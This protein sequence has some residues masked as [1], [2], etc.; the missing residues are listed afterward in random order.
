MKEP[1][2]FKIKKIIIFPLCV[3]FLSHCS[4]II[5]DSDK[6]IF[7]QNQKAEWIHDKKTL[8]SADSLF[9]LEDPTPLFRKVFFLKDSP[10]KVTLHITAAGYYKA[11]INTSHLEKNIL[12]PAWTDFSKRIY[13]NEYNI[14]PKVTKGMNCLAV[15]LGNGFY[16]PLPLKMW[17]KINLRERLPVGKPRFIAK[18]TIVHQ[19]GKIEEIV[20]DTSWK[21]S[22]GPTIKNSIYL[23]THYDARKEIAGWNQADFDDSEWETA[24]TAEAPGGKLQKTFFPSIQINR[25][26]KPLK[27]YDTKDGKWLVDMGEN[28]TGT[29]TI[30]LKGQRGDKTTFR[31]G[32]R[33]YE[34]GSLN[35][36]T[37]VIGQIKKKGIGGPGAPDIAWQ[38]DSHIMGDENPTWFR[39]EFTYH[40]YRYMEIDGLNKKPKKDEIMGLSIH[41]QVDEENHFSSSSNL[42][43]DI[44]NTVRRTFLANLMGVQSDC[45]AREKFGYGGDLN[46]TSAS[47][48]FN[49][50]MQSFYKKTIYDWVD[51]INDSTFVDTAP[52]V[53][54]QYCGISWES[55]F[56][57]TQYQLYLHYKDLEFVKE[58]YSFNNQWMDK[59]ARIHPDGIVHTGLSDHESLI[60]VP[61]ELIGTIHYLQSART[62]KFFA[63]LMGDNINKNKY[64]ELALE[65]EKKLRGEFWDKRFEGEINRQTLFS[66]LLYHKIIPEDQINAAK[67]SLLNALKKAPSQHLN[68]GIFGTQFAL[69]AVSQFLSPQIIFDI[70]NSKDYPGWGHMVD[71]GATTLWETWKE[72]DNVYSNSHPMFGSVTEWFYRWLGGIRPDPNHPG[73]ESFFIKPFTPKGLKS[74]STTYASP[75]GKIISNWTKENDESYRYII[76]VPKASRAQ[77]ILTKKPDQKI[78]LL[79]GKEYL[80]LE[81]IAGL[82]DGDFTLKSGK[83]VIHVSQ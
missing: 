63:G 8:P 75:S 19:N 64:D 1:F 35:P 33:L 3:L 51:A 81:D 74:V 10:K 23:G 62:M 59:V 45:P 12:D 65:L 76:S 37:S 29:Y 83:Y 79:E 6:T 78:N 21:Y 24:Q 30:K 38:S 49:F 26:I 18:L 48:I 2:S 71:R 56:L 25:K 4:K 46:A 66:S 73:F 60:P 9:Y 77:V 50:N 67:D 22:F 7:F 72:S 41:S 52:S 27:I 32:E 15:T 13:Y 16:N 11:Y 31:F 20:S 54:I 61:V 55:A 17:G 5:S 68:T 42:L 39:P 47:F 57:I 28:F 58:L 69:E 34:D 14:T 36:M 53:G 80:S 40:A 82:K 43:N 70:I 44:Q